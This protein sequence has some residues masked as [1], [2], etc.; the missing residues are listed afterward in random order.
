MC[1]TDVIPPQAVILSIRLVRTIC[2]F[3]EL[4]AALP[5]GD[6][7]VLGDRMV[8]I[9]LD[10]RARDRI[11]GQRIVRRRLDQACPTWSARR[12][13]WSA[14]RPPARCRR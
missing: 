7:D 12:G 4:V 9:E 14:R 11:G 10:Q 8:G 13:R 5:V 1:L 2:A 3:H 6:G